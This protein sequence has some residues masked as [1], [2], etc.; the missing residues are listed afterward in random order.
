MGDSEPLVSVVIPTTRRDEYL[1]TAIDS[2]SAQT[3]EQIQVVVV[4]DSEGSHQRPVDS[5]SDHEVVHI[6]DGDHSGPADARNTGIDRADGRYI[7]FLDDDDL[8]EPEK[9]SRQ[10]AAF[11]RSRPQV[12][13]V[14][15]GRRA[16]DSDGQT[17]SVRG[18][19]VEGD[20]I[21]RILTGQPLNPIS[22]VMVR[23]DNVA[24][25]GLLD[26]SFR[27]WEDREWFLRLS[28]TGDFF[29]IDEP[30]TI[31]RVGHEQLTNDFQAKEAAYYR[32]LEKHRELTSRFGPRIER[33]F[34]AWLSKCVGISAAQTGRYDAAVEYLR[35]SIQYEPL[36]THVYPYFFLAVGGVVMAPVVRRV[37]DRVGGLESQL[38]DWQRG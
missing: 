9:L 20:T 14:L 24:E 25:A 19:T 17:V 6:R 7:A 22:C 26:E 28:F 11:E 5:F 34:V 30:L 21:R 4:D 23:R 32:F 13:M 31:R 12:G 10:V 1:R 2:V 37:K 36:D 16:V 27:F 33:K 35:R 15:T 3:Y 8:W 29:G 38:V 18:S